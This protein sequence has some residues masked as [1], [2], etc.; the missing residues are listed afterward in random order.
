MN[1][2][3][4]LANTDFQFRQSFSFTFTKQTLQAQKVFN[5]VVA[6]LAELAKF[7][8]AVIER[9]TIEMLSPST[10]T[11]VAL[12][13]DQYGQFY[14]TLCMSTALFSRLGGDISGF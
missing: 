11:A 14:V 1:M 3:S 12:V 7:E 13:E 10:S 8:V 6:R 4:E 2:V 9:R 5:T